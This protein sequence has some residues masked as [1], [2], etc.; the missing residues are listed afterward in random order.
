TFGLYLDADF[1][2]G[3]TA[4]CETFGNEPLT[5][6]VDFTV[7]GLEIVYGCVLN[8]QIYHFKVQ[9]ECYRACLCFTTVR[10]G[11]DLYS[12]LLLRRSLF[13]YYFALQAYSLLIVFDFLCVLTASLKVWSDE[14]KNESRNSFS[15]GDARFDVLCIFGTTVLVQLG[16]LFVGKECLEHILEKSGDEKDGQQHEPTASDSF[17]ILLLSSLGTFV[18]HLIAYGAQLSQNTSLNVVLNGSSS[19]WLQEHCADISHTLCRF[20][21]GLSRLLLPR[22]NPLSFL[23]VSGLSFCALTAILI[24]SNDCNACDSF[25]AIC[26]LFMI[27]G[28]MKP[29]AIYT[30]RILLQTS[31]AHALPQLDKSMREASTLDGVLEIADDHF[32]Q[33][34]LNRMAGS[35]VVRVRRDA[36]EQLVLSQV[37]GKLYPIVN[38]LTIQINK[39]T[40]WRPVPKNPVVEQTFRNIDQ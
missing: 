1:Y 10:E 27:I 5:D 17:S 23:N 35:V 30:G 32:W 18:C 34:S 9:Y 31:P 40:S 29:L 26:L 11:G 24:E 33:L 28:T 38:D 15:Y 21:P 4:H 12:S 14:T 7:V 8:L 6:P 19:S 39:D 25:I 37:T 3:R 20:I 13:L 16:A 36:D 22:V 2:H